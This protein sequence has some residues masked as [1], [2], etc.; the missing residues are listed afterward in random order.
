MMKLETVHVTNLIEL[1]LLEDDKRTYFFLFRNR[2][3]ACSPDIFI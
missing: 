2:V 1:F 3:N